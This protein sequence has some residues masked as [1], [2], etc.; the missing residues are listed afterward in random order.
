MSLIAGTDDTERPVGNPGRLDAAAKVIQ[1]GRYRL[2]NKLR[3]LVARAPPSSRCDGS[4]NW[5]TAPVPLWLE[6][7][8]R[9][10]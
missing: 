5:K 3:Y 8:M 4:V 7:Q 1:S 9:P 10:P 2:N 6:A